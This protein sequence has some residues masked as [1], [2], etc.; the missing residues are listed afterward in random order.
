MQIRYSEIFYSF[1][2]EAEFAGTPAVWLRFFG[3]NLNCSGFG[4]K[5]PTDP[6]TYVLPYQTFDVNSVKRIEDLPIWTH[7][8]DSSYS[9]SSRFKHLITPK[10]VKETCDAIE[11]KLRSEHNPEGLF[12]HPKTGQSTMLCFTGGE[13]MLWQKQMIAV[14]EE[15]KS[16][17]NIPELVTIE[18]NATRPITDELRDFI[19]DNWGVQFHFA[20]SPKL[21]NV[22]GEK[23]VIDAANI[24]DYHDAGGSACLKFVVNGTKAC[25]DELEGALARIRSEVDD[26]GSSMPDVWVMP[27]GATAE[28]HENIG[29]LVIESMQRGYKVATRNQVYVFG[30]VIGS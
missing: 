10:S 19:Y 6:S 17:G 21:F 27:V 15:L 23:D 11:E 5:D 13:P 2:G 20:M 22:S 8:C 28:S 30:N 7:G 18:T 29:P 12:C 3:C 14:L 9:W 25:W 26:R 24:I 1:Q 4:Q 16:R